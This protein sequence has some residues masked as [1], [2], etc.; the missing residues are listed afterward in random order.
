MPSLRRWVVVGGGTAGCIVACGL[1][2]ERD[3]EVLLLERGRG[4]GRRPGRSSFDDLALAGPWD[5]VW[6]T[7]DGNRRMYPIGT[8]L[9]GTSR[10]N[11][12]LV[13]VGQRPAVGEQSTRGWAREWTGEPVSDDELGP[14]DT[15]LRAAAPDAAN[16]RLLRRAGRLLDT[17]SVTGVG[18]G[19]SVG[20]GA[21]AGELT[22]RSGATVRAVEVV[23]DR[24]VGVVLVDGERVAADAVVLC[25]GAIGSAALLL[26][27]GVEVA[28]LGAVR[29]HVGRVIELVLRPH[30]AWDPAAL[31]TGVGLRRGAA[32][33]LAL[34]HLGPGVAGHGALLAGWLAGTRRGSITVAED[35]ARPP[36][37][38]F[39]A[40]AGTPDA[41]G[42]ALAEAI[43]AELLD[44]PSFRAL[45]AE[46]RRSSALS[47]YFHAGS[48]CARGA[49]LDDDGRVVGHERLFVADAAALPDLPVASTMFTAVI[50]EARR[51]VER[52]TR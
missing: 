34:N 25:A 51:F 19:A 8:G 45:V 41:A 14:V 4:S 42:L 2:A 47:G 39:G 36:D 18:G 29:Q 31:A 20:G 9:G 27:S 26:R 48:S 5:H 1:A 23:D 46:H 32:E 7:D 22:V 21:L 24:A 6:V 44:H 16:V 37:V 15:A 43:A 35:P 40:L 11:G 52:S 3:N 30:V 12:A 28:G 13:A 50:A 49:V 38:D 33:V 17:A 10:I